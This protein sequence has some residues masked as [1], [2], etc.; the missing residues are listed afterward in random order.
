[1][2]LADPLYGAGIQAY[3]P[4]FVLGLALLWVGSNELAQAPEAR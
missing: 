3:F 4:L 1:M 2:P